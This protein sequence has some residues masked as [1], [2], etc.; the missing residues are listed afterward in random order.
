MKRKL[1]SLLAVVLMGVLGAATADE[2]PIL[3]KPLPDFHFLDTAQKIQTLSGLME[4]KDA[5]LINL[6][7]S[8]CRP[9][10][11]EYPF[12]NQ[13]Y[14][15]YGDRVAFIGLS[16]D[17]EDTLF[18]IK[19]IKK[20][21]KLAYPVGR[22]EHSGLLDYLGGSHGTPTTII[23][24]RFG[25]A[26][27]LQVGAFFSYD[28]IERLMEE[29]LAEDY[30]ESRPLVRLPLPTATRA[31]P[32]ASSRHIWV[33]EEDARHVCVTTHFGNEEMAAWYGDQVCDG[34]VFSGDS[35]RL[36]MT[37]GPGD[38]PQNIEFRDLN[39]F[40]NFEMGSLLDPERNLYT[41]EMPMIPDPELDTWYNVTLGIKEGY[42]DDDPAYTEVIIFPDEDAIRAFVAYCA[43]DGDT[44]TWEYTDEVKTGPENGTEGAYILRAIDQYGQPVTGVTASFCTAETCYPA[45][46]DENGVITFTGEK[47]NYHVQVVK[48]PERTRADK[49]F[50]LQTGE[51]Y[52]EWILVLH[53]E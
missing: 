46:A 22:E 49:D 26:V 33:E 12:L 17:P 20:D 3:G 16:V 8:W 18:D 44:V 38:D 29:F 35:I 30:T 39:N 40:I 5:A 53:R 36:A 32:V 50:E 25:N 31:L 37:L 47:Q 45:K 43:E 14:E 1:M 13:A 28:Q 19:E 24:D 15:K 2:S 23:V 10:K 9:C 34:W 27:Y 7:T 41:Y 48:T 51:E 6:W 42:I 4:G 11:L 52:G 21:Y